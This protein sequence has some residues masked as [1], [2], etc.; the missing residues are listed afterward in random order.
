MNKILIWYVFLHSTSQ[1]NSIINS[2]YYSLS[3]IH[4]EVCFIQKNTF[5]GIVITDGV[6]NSFAIF[7]Y[8]RTC[9]SLLSQRCDEEAPVIIGFQGDVDFFSLYDPSSYRN[10]TETSRSE[11]DPRANGSTTDGWCNLVYQLAPKT[12][13]DASKYYSF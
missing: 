7:T 12:P 4:A 13:H 1:L 6:A 11:P 10:Q 3:F 9:A 5:Q 8:Q 2:Y